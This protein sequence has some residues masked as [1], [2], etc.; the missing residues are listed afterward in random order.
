MLLNYGLL[1]MT[2]VSKLVVV[3]GFKFGGLSTD[4]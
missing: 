4:D 2:P 3:G 1:P